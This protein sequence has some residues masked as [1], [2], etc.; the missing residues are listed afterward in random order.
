MVQLSAAGLGV[1]T[2]NAN[3]SIA[4]AITQMT[5]GFVQG[6]KLK[7]LRDQQDREKE[8]W[9][10]QKA[11]DAAQARAYGILGE[12]AGWQPNSAQP[13]GPPGMGGEPA[14]GGIISGP[15]PQDAAAQA[16][17]R[18]GSDAFFAPS[19]TTPAQGPPSS[20][21]GSGPSVPAQVQGPAFQQVQGPPAQKPLDASAVAAGAMSSSMPLGQSL[22]YQNLMA[23][24]QALLRQLMPELG[25]MDPRVA[26]LVHG[27]V[28]EGFK[29]DADL[30]SR[31][32][33]TSEVHDQWLR[34]AFNEIGPDGSDIQ[35]PQL[36]EMIMGIA[37]QV[38]TGQLSVEDGNAQL[39]G[40]KMQAA[41]S[42]LQ[43][44]QRGSRVRLAEGQLA[45]LEQGGTVPHPDAHSAFDTFKR[46]GDMRTFDE[47][48]PE[49]V[50]GNVKYK[51]E[52]VKP[53]VKAAREQADTDNAV[54]EAK[55]R[56][57]MA[58]TYTPE[59]MLAKAR[60]EGRGD[61]TKQLQVLMESMLQANQR[62]MDTNAREMTKNP[63]PYPVE[64]MRSIA[65][66]LLGP[67]QSAEQTQAPKAPANEE[68][69]ENPAVPENEQ[70][71][72]TDVV[73]TARQLEA[74]T[75]PKM[76]QVRQ[77]EIA[78]TKGDDFARAV[79]KRMRSKAPAPVK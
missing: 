35:D 45:E 24:Q 32:H 19:T 7:M 18:T 72:D 58:W 71:E 38:E 4:D 65:E 16:G 39:N 2:S 47:D 22:D 77:G 60:I 20:A 67:D 5:Q 14:A 52:W 63:A 42:R 61:R 21:T 64:Q 49:Y 10:R 17:P 56:A 46:G 48:W 43:A 44:L 53:D 74:I 66:R 69:G 26:Q 70:A 59:G 23:H 6:A 36:G 1:P 40:L 33:F 62:T 30:L 50:K 79:L 41:H 25:K 13:Q 31:S 27:Q 55:Q 15:Q 8:Q 75:D 28:L 34:G 11:Q 3:A 51:N 76:R 9:E 57:A 29:R 73:E 78:K 54:A 12:Q 68:S 37:K